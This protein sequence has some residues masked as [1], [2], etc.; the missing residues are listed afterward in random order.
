MNYHH[1]FIV[2][3]IKKALINKIGKIYINNYEQNYEKVLM[4]YF[5]NFSNF[6]EP[7]N[8]FKDTKIN[9]VDEK[10]QKYIN[11]FKKPN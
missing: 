3:I 9:N 1:L 8:K 6:I 11:A 2:L 10:I 7:R 5:N 4:S